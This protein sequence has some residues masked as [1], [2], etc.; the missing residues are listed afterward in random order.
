MHQKKQKI[1]KKQQ[2]HI[3]HI[4]SAIAGYACLKLSCHYQSKLF[5]VCTIFL[6]VLHLLCYCSYDSLLDTW[7]EAGESRPHFS[8]LVKIFETHLQAVSHY[9]E[10]N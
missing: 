8:S 7:K 4:C 2:Q 10:W 3:F 1:N 5:A 9:M 6:M